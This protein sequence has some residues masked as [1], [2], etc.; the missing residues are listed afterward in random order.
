MTDTPR[1]HVRIDVIDP[2]VLAGLR[3][4]QQPGTPDLLSQLV[5]LFLDDAAPRL[6]TLAQT[7]AQGD[8]RALERQAHSLKGSSV[9]LGARQMA[10]LCEQ[11]EALGRSGELR[12]APE[13]LAQLEAAF[14]RARAALRAEV[15][16]A[17]DGAAR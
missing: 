3:G 15:S 8:A 2:A 16:K 1:D 10:R 4:L 11:L 13:V 9:N 5:E 7:L 14:D 6:A 12:R 17:G